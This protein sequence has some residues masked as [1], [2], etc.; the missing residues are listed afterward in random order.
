MSAAERTNWGMLGC[1]ALSAAAHTGVAVATLRVAAGWEGPGAHTGS[2]SGLTLER[3]T[4]VSLPMPAV[5]PPP[6]PPPAVE[7]P[8]P[9]PET[10]APEA[11]EIA[12]GRD[13][14]DV[15]SA[16][17]IGAAPRDAK[18]ASGRR[19]SIDQGAYALPAGELEPSPAIPASEGAPGDA[20]SRP[21]AEDLSLVPAQPKTEQAAPHVE[22]PTPPDAAKADAE[23]KPEASKPSD[24]VAPTAKAATAPQAQAMFGQDPKAKD[25][26]TEPAKTPA[27]LLQQAQRLIN[28]ATALIAT[29]DGDSALKPMDGA[30]DTEPTIEPKPDA[31]DE[32]DQELVEETPE[33]TERQREGLGDSP[34]D[35]PEGAAIAKERATAPALTREA[36][37][38]LE[39]STIEDAPKDPTPTDATV[40]ADSPASPD[41]PAVPAGRQASPGSEPIPVG[42][43]PDSTSGETSDRESIA[44]AIREAIKVEPGQP[45]AGKGLTVKT[46]RPRWSHFTLITAAPQNAVVRVEFGKD[47]RV[48][49]VETLRSSGRNDVDRPML[50][51]VYMWT[52]S[53]KQL[54]DLPDIGKDGKPSTVR[55]TFEMILGR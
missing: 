31:K 2:N 55:M 28:E 11:P 21:G 7:E 47:G 1:L 8:A 54:R 35:E 9:Q 46:V 13:D 23:A 45:V 43:V 26:K 6:P 25:D 18:E 24:D 52:A 36:E 5:T 37:P 22:T 14:S 30:P 17:W 42:V 44:A 40:D 41:G 27:E 32:K 10:K 33:R 4:L 15:E 50:D 39:L 51:A 20:A 12:L 49:S 34:L 29:K 53:G 19:S 38:T 16:T 48:T 3:E